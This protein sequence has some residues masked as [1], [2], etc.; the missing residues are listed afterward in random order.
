MD[1]S[2]EQSGAERIKKISGLAKEKTFW[3]SSMIHH[4]LFHFQTS[5]HFKLTS[6][7]WWPCSSDVCAPNS[8]SDISAHLTKF[9]IELRRPVTNNSIQVRACAVMQSPG[10]LFDK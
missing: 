4:L 6:H 3:S 10:Q 5:V 1:S 8:F 2:T 9:S 7:Q